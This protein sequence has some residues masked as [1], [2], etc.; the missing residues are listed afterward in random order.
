ML[1]QTL[2]D[3]DSSFNSLREGNFCAYFLAKLRPNSGTALLE[4]DQPPFALQDFLHSDAMD[5]IF[6]SLVLFCS[7]LYLPK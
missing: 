5:T 7:L 3:R 2:E 6:A 4:L 1:S